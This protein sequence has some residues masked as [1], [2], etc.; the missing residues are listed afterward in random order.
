MVHS[1]EQGE[2]TGQGARRNSIST[3]S[4]RTSRPSN[5][6][7]VQVH[8]I[9]HVH[10]QTHK[11]GT[12][13]SSRSSCAAS[14]SSSVR[15]PDWRLHRSS[16]RG[17]PA[18]AQLTHEPSPDAEPHAAD[19]ADSSSRSS[20]LPASPCTPNGRRRL[21]IDRIN[22][23]TCTC[24]CSCRGRICGACRASPC[25]YAG[26]VP[27]HCRRSAFPLSPTRHPADLLS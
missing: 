21:R 13:A 22:I 17:A 14:S 8:T 20:P 18:R 26:P 5:A 9:T 4:E 7:H 19:D 1:V 25:L 6:I 15:P 23:C 11:P 3:T 12:S 2:I 10:A 16:K 27:V 24:A